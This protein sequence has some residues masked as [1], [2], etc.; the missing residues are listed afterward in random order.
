V[1]AIEVLAADGSLHV[2][3][4][5]GDVEA[6]NGALVGLGGIGAVT[7]L[8]L[9]VVPTFDVHQRVYE[10]LPFSAAVEHFDVVTAAAYSVSLFTDWRSDS[11]IQ[12]WLKHR[13]GGDAAGDALLTSF[14]ATPASRRL[15]PI[16]GISAENCT[17]QLGIPGPWHERL[18][19]FRMEFTPSAGEELQSEYFVPRE[20]AAAAL[21]AI[22]AMRDRIAPLLQISE[23]RTIAADEF[24]MSPCYR[25]PSVAIHFTWRKDWP[26][27]RTL[28]PT[29]EAQLAPFDARP[30]WGKLFTMEPVRLRGLYPRM[31]DFGELARASDPLGKFRN[32]FLD[33]YVFA[34]A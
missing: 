11:I 34:V 9:D 29:I 14:G 1:H 17:E 27:V 4:R 23:I 10:T 28:L 30:H 19:H 16:P 18:P 24:W 20:H 12:V 13:G 7:K 32:A 15:H 26:A 2:F 3:S 6:F 25:R 31:N 21:T 5:D 22:D 8:T 33:R